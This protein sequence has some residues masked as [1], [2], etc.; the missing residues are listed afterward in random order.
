M[1]LLIIFLIFLFSF[2]ALSKDTELK[3]FY[4]PRWELTNRSIEYLIKGEILADATVSSKDKAQ[5]FKMQVAAV[6]PKPCRKVLRKLAMLEKFKD[7]I[8]FIKSSKYD[9]KNRLWTLKAN[10]TLLPYPMLVHIIL[11]RP[12]STG[13]YPFTFP[14]GIFTGLKG[15][16]IIKKY[17]N[18]CAFYAT[19]YW[20]GKD[21][22]LPNFI[23][24]L[25]SETLTKIGGEIVFRKIN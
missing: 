23:I 16:F 19:S 10:H 7:W 9:E 1:K 14:T 13:K 24:E 15:H 5:E 12:K 8:G 21:T 3:N 4:A 20:K 2:S 18:K 22:K 25:F 11:D 6:H 17:K